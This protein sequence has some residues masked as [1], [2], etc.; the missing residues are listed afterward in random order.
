[1]SHVVRSEMH[2][3]RQVLVEE[4]VQGVRDVTVDVVTDL[5]R[6]FLLPEAMAVTLLGDLEGHTVDFL[7]FGTAASK[8]AAR[9][10]VNT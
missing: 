10:V 4:I 8:A 5:A 7:P 2:Y 9:P 6:E 1:M 3:G